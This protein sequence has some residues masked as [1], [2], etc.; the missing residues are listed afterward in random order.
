MIESK[1][2]TQRATDTSGELIMDNL[3]IAAWQPPKLG[4]A[5]ARQVAKRLDKH[6][7]QTGVKKL[8]DIRDALGSGVVSDMPMADRVEHQAAVKKWKQSLSK[9]DLHKMFR[10]IEEIKNGKSREQYRKTDKALSGL[11]AAFTQ[12]TNTMD[13]NLRI[14]CIKLAYEKPELRPYL[15]PLLK[16]EA[17]RGAITP[18]VDKRSVRDGTATMVWFLDQAKNSSKFYEQLITPERG[19]GYKL[20]RQWGR[21]TDQGAAKSRATKD[22]YFD[23]EGSAQREMQKRYMKSLRSGYIDAFGNKHR[24]PDGKKLPMGEYPV[25]LGDVGGLWKGEEAAACVPELRYI[26]DSIGEAMTASSREDAEGLLYSLESANRT[27]ERLERS[28][29]S[30]ALQKMMRNPL[31]RMQGARSDLALGIIPEKSKTVR[32]LGT[33]L[34]YLNKRLSLCGR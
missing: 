27:L 12:G 28:D 32:E 8:Q 4:K 5:L 18:G 15:L 33:M 23:D 29:L 17:R 30:K 14:A 21:L 22:L 13:H 11:R 25:G 10:M 19:G 31:G 24:T 7:A 3:R 9:T 6:W 2:Y 26:M 34:R 1:A 16:K 20:F